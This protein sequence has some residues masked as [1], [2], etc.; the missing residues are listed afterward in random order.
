MSRGYG[1]KRGWQD[2]RNAFSRLEQERKAE[3]PF[4]N[5]RRVISSS[6]YFR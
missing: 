4:Y 2:K 6:K 1:K 5:F 3:G